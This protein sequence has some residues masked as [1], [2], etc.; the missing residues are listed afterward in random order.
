MSNARK[1]IRYEGPL[2]PF[3]ERLVREKRDSGYQYNTGS[4]NIPSGF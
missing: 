1:N 3:M 2:A 4:T